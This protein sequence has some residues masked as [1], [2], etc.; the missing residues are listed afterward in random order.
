[1]VAGHAAPFEA[2]VLNVTPWKEDD[3]EARQIA[4]QLGLSD[5]MPRT[6]AE[7]RRLARERRRRS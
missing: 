7:A 4:E 5:E 2:Y 6:M 1:M 3:P